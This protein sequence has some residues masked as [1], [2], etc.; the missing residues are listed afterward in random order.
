MNNSTIQGADYQHTLYRN[1]PGKSF[2]LFL[3]L[4]AG[5]IPFRHGRAQEIK[6]QD[7]I[8]PNAEYP[9]FWT[10]Q[11]NPVLLLGGSDEDNLFQLEGFE[12]QLDL[13]VAVGGNYVRN[14]MSS[15]DS[16]NLWPFYFDTHSAKYDLNRWNEDYWDRFN[17]F[18]EQ[19]NSRDIIVQI[20]IW[21]TFDFYRDN[22]NLNP[23]N[24]VNNTNY[25]GERTKLPAEIKTH[26][27]WCDNPFF[28]SIPS[29]HNNMPVLT[30][31][32]RYVDKLLS[33]SLHYGNILYCIDNETSVT[34]EWG[35]F[36]TNYIRKKAEESGR[37]V[38]I[39]E[40][41]DPH[42]LN[43]VSHRES[44]D[45]PEIY[46]FVEISQNN[47]KSG[48]EHWNNG[49]QLLE[50]VR[51]ME[52]KR[53][54]TNIKVYGNDGG[55]HQTTQNAIES[56][57][58]NVLMGCASSRF[59]RPSSGQGLNETAQAVIKSVRLAQEN[60]SH[61]KA[62][63]SNHLLMGRENDEAYCRAIENQEYLIYFPGDGEISLRLPF[64]KAV[65]TL[66]WIEILKSI[67]S[68]PIQLTGKDTIRIKSPD[69]SHY[70]AVI[71][72]GK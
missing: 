18:L 10:Y 35:S 60:F 23:F 55:R 4:L 59:H 57:C 32:Q 53:P 16:G 2:I 64:D 40:M 33:Y 24:P 15:R 71:V 37:T 49:L 68:E 66:Q 46:S 27:T 62:M 51:Q 12:K 22:W 38:Y 47:H 6:N 34:S 21:A 9:Q 31:Q 36:W 5:I 65:F 70:L 3:S 25:S 19:C 7:W 48:Q 72:A 26:P 44:I 58:K 52:V 67:E 13:L 1:I 42:D 17:Y 50:R 30:Y 14:T 20:E 41:W 28:W 45:H 39:T 11:G 69:N 54:V 56:F 8:A 63:P 43:H 29:Q 61:F